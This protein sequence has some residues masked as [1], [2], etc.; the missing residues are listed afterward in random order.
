MFLICSILPG[1]VLIV[2]GYDRAKPGFVVARSE[3]VWLRICYRLA[4]P[5]GLRSH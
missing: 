2:D 3:M 5:Y 1:L 4:Q